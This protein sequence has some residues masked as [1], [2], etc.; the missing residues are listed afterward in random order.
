MS[1]C[2]K[3]KMS[4]SR[5][6]KRMANWKMTAP[7]LIKCSKCGYEPDPSQPAPKFCTECGDPI[8]PED[9]KN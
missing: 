4:K 9:R 3:N 5:M 1:I 2:P 8:G 6:D 7:T